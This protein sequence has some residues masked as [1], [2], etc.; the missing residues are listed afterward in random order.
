MLEKLLPSKIITVHDGRFHADEIFACATLSLFH[1]RRIKIIRT[2]NEELWKKADYVVDVGG[3]YDHETECY[4]HHQK[5]GA[6]ERENGIPYASFGL[7]WKHYGPLVCRSKNVAERIDKFLVQPIDAIDNGVSIFD[8]NS[9]GVSPYMIQSIVQS[10]FP[11]WREEGTIDLDK[12]FVNLVAF[13]K[14]ILER[15]IA[16]TR[17]L[18][19]A[20]NHMAALYDE[21]EDK[22]VIVL[23]ANYPFESFMS[24]YKE[25]IFVVSP[26]VD[27]TWRVGVIPKDGVSFSYRKKLPEAWAGLHGEAL[28]HITNIKGAK[29]CHRA[30]F[31]CVADKK[32]TAIKLA[33]KALEE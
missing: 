30:L 8:Q 1:K 12:E 29:F 26:R 11:S 16:K 9:F 22:R 33:Y 15:E 4:D 7:V 20:E 5:G 10:R 31:L 19:M 13:A 27:G 14:Q 24:T 18:L 32:E 21:T 6:G 25:P 3:V 2:R 28:E 23:D 17:D